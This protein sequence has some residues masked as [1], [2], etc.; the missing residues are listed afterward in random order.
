MVEWLKQLVVGDGNV[1]RERSYTNWN[2]FDDAA[3]LAEK[4]K[5]SSTPSGEESSDNAED[6]GEDPAAERP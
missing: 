6:T 2:T 5:E 1:L 4:V 3:I